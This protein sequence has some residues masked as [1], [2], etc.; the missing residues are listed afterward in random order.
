[1]SKELVSHWDA[2]KFGVISPSG[3]VI[4]EDRKG[5]ISMKITE[6]GKHPYQILRIDVFE[7]GKWERTQ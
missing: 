1:M 3:E 5:G 2:F 7:H 4:D 6:H